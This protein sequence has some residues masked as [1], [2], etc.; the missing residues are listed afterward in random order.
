MLTNSLY[1]KKQLIKED[2]KK[3]LKRILILIRKNEIKRIKEK[4]ILEYEKLNKNLS[5]TI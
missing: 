5:R 4:T 2:I 1:L 3:Y